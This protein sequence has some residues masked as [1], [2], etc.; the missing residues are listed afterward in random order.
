MNLYTINAG[1][2]KLD[3]GAMF[4]VVPKSMWNKLNPADE[5]NM[6]S[7]ALRCLLIEDEGKLILIDNG[8]GDKQDAKFFGH[9]YLHGDDS[10]DKSLAQHGFTK[11][12]ITDVF[13]THLHFDHCGGSIIRDG[14]KLVPAFKNAVY[15]SNEQH[16]EWATKPNDRERA[17]FL[18]ENI[19]PI[20]ESGQLKMVDSIKVTD[21]SKDN[22]NTVICHPTT[23]LPDLSFYTVNGH[24]G[25]M[26]LPVIKYNDKTIVY[27][28]DLLPSVAH[29][30][31]PYV[32]GYD[33][34]PLTTLNEK[35]IFLI[36]A[37][38][39]NY[40]LFFEHDPVNECCN[41]QMTE[42]GIRVKDVFKLNQI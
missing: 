10:L 4:G 13:L 11:D 21:D 40:T 6:C 39:N 3:G 22:T 31:L 33:M 26:M 7:W 14:D 15:W 34:F 35:K 5:N 17:S 41:L 12:D 32:M 36:E 27:M 8:M 1:Y 38:E 29:I 28:A 30:P 18:K 25:A 20:K 9:Y 23:I 19:V 2:F 42:K 16:W 37:L 24:T